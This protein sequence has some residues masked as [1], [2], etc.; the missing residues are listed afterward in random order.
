MLFKKKEETT[1]MIKVQGMMC[2]NCVKHVTEG[3]EKLKGVKSVDVNLKDGTATIV[4]TRPIYDEELKN[5]VMDSGYKYGG[6][7]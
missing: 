3:L 2:M 7:I 1:I 6:R 4:A 5:A